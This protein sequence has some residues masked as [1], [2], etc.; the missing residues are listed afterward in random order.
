VDVGDAGALIRAKAVAGELNR[1]CGVLSL[2]DVRRGLAWMNGPKWAWESW[3][4]RV[5][6][7]ARSLVGL[8]RRS[9]LNLSLEDAGVGG[10]ARGG[11]KTV[12]SDSYPGGGGSCAGLHRACQA[13]GCVGGATRRAFN[14]EL[15]IVTTPCVV[16][17]GDGTLSV[18]SSDTLHVRSR[19]ARGQEEML[20]RRREE[21]TSRHAHLLI[22]ER[23]KLSHRVRGVT[24]EGGL[25]ATLRRV[26][27]ARVGAK[28][29]P[30]RD[31]GAL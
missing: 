18:V 20:E 26:S 19:G 24:L 21:T 3:E 29:I 5:M 10:S 11:S 8:V 28:F 6:H 30:A 13:A 16:E 31:E 23:R 12:A 25:W 17:R 7:P 27:P 4:C 9:N 1:V 14:D 15:T 2:Q 22:S